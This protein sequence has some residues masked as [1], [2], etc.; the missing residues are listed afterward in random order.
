MAVIAATE[1][2][3]I[4][5]V[6]TAFA[7]TVR[8]VESIPGGWTMDTLQR[9]LQFA[10]GIY[11]AF[12][13]MAAGQTEGYHD[14][15]F[16]VYAVTKGADEAARRRGT[17]RVIGA[18]DIVEVMVQVL[19]G[20]QVHDVATAAVTGVENLFRDA[21]F[22][23]GGTVYGVNVTLPNMPLPFEADPDTLADFVTFRAEHSMAPGDDEPAAIDQVTLPQ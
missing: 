14:G 20:L 8:Q 5:A 22:E 17:P 10:P 6:K 11:V 2:A 3:L 9:A 21:M 23:L 19:D 15:R 18:Y 12:H 4:E 1:D 13:G 16:T 7:A